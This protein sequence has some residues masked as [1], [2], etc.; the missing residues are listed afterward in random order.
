VI[1]TRPIII[2]SVRHHFSPRIRSLL[3]QY[4][5]T[6]LTV[7]LGPTITQIVLSVKIG[8]ISV[9]GWHFIELGAPAV[10]QYPLHNTPARMITR[11]EDGK[12]N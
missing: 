2:Q 9:C 6:A 7:S 11:N 12:L 3:A 10:L 8:L 1:F 5:I 4:S